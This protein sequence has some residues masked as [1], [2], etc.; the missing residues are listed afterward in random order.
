VLVDAVSESTNVSEIGTFL[1][2]LKPQWTEYIFSFAADFTET[3]SVIEDL[4]P[5]DISLLLDLTTILRNSWPNIAKPGQVQY[6]GTGEILGSVVKTI[7]SG[8]N[9][10]LPALFEDPASGF[11]SSDEGRI[12]EVTGSASNNGEYTIYKALSTDHVLVTPDFVADELAGTNVLNIEAVTQLQDLSATFTTDAVIDNIVTIA[13]GPNIGDYRIIEV[14][15]NNNLLIRETVLDGPFAQKEI[16]RDFIITSY[17]WYQDQ[18]SIDFLENFLHE[19]SDGSTATASTF[20]VDSSLDLY[21][22]GVM[23]GFLL[24]IKSGANMNVYPI[25]SVDT[26][27]QITITGTFPSFPVGS[28]DYAIA[29]AALVRSNSSPSILEVIPI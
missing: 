6:T 8:W 25:V 28:Q 24:I 29:Q 13:D 12:I 26:K 17:T 5:S 11:S 1:E 15:D 22:M 16:G 4:H 23:A 3:L 21:A 7:A 9:V 27:A 19:R 10:S 2:N 14:V 20:T 18:G